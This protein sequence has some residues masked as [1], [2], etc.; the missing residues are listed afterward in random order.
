MHTRIPW[1]LF[2]LLAWLSPA[3]QARVVINEIF[4]HA[5]DDVEDLEYIEL[6]NSGDQ[7]V[8]LGGWAFTRGIK[9]KFPPGTQIKPKG[10]LVLCRNRE[11]FKEY[12]D[13]PVAGVFDQALSNKGERVEL[14]DASGKA[15][16]AVRYSDNAPWPMGADGYSGS[17]ERIS[18]EANGEDPANW[19]SSPLSEDRIKPAGT[20]GKANANYSANLPPVIS[21]LRFAPENPLPGQPIAVEAEVSDTNGVGEVNLLYRLAGPGFEKPESS[22]SMNKNS[23]GRYAATIPAQGKDQLIR[24]RIQATDTK[25]ARRS[26]PAE[27]EPS[28]AFSS[29]VHGPINPAGIPFGWVID[30]T[31]KQFNADWNAGR[32]RFGPGDRRFAGPAN[33]PPG[34]S[35]FLYYDPETDKLELFDFVQVVPRGGGLKIHFLKHRPLRQM[36]TINLIFESEDRFVLAEPLAYEVYRKAGNAA[37][38]S[39]HVR[40]WFNGQPAGYHLLVEQPNRAFLRR[41]HIRDDGNLY[42]ILWYEQGVVKQHK[43]K[44]HTRQGHTDIVELV[45]A[46]ENTRGD[47]Q[48]E[49]IKQNFEVEQVIN[50]F[51]VNMVLSHWDGFFNNY[52]TYHDLNGAGKW[53]MYQW[54]QDKTWG[55]HRSE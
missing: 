19:A 11:R 17:L 25:G 42:K 9:F 40:L 20:P 39:F 47:A 24:F 34:G 12:Y 45:K 52:F 55:F 21:N 33:P 6:H 31:R 53:T 22:V 18:P 35:A 16:D 2:L 1:Q 3:V 50:Y 4:Y 23:E 41:N 54:D 30:T 13:A 27:T 5:P 26:F 29:Y 48:W 7:P 28:P 44:T 10:F 38:Q 32:D 49:V 36:T 14:S 46:L 51:A 8:D 15:V 37:E 43:K